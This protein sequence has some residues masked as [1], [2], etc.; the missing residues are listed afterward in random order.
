MPEEVEISEEIEKSCTIKTPEV[1][2]YNAKI[3]ARE[4]ALASKDK[5]LRNLLMNKS[6]IVE[7]GFDKESWVLD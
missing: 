6:I 2:I 4:S 3:I 5:K 7:A 1:K